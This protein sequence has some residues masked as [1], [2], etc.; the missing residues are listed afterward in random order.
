DLT[1]DFDAVL[2]KLIAVITGQAAPDA[3]TP[4]A[5]HAPRLTGF[6]AYELE[7]Y[8]LLRHLP[9]AGRADELSQINEALPKAIV[10]VVAIG[11]RG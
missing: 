11:G 7:Y 2:T 8:P 10:Q 6:D 3:T 9:L 4:A 5:A 1:A